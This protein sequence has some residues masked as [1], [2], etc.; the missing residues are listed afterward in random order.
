MAGAA[1]C[2]TWLGVAGIGLGLRVLGAWP[3]VWLREREPGARRR[4]V[5]SEGARGGRGIHCRVGERISLAIE[6]TP[7]VLKGDLAALRLQ[8]LDQRARL[9]SQGQQ[10]G[11]PALGAVLHE[12][13]GKLRV[14]ADGDQEAWRRVR[15]LREEVARELEAADEPAEL[16]DVVRGAAV[17]QER[18]ARGQHGT[19]AVPHEH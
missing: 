17:V 2:G 8:H 4:E 13:D 11:V 5:G 9:V 10:G 7:R 14:A 15:A 1:R 19:G 6:G 3:G 16:R 12:V 18:G